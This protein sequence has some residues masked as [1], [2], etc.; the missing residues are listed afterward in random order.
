MGSLSLAIFF[1]NL[2]DKNKVF[3][4][5]NQKKP[6][7]SFGRCFFSPENRAALPFFL[8]SAL[9]CF[10]TRGGCGYVA[11]D[12]EKNSTFALKYHEV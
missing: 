7:K 1:K 11:R 8:P 6:N 2:T 3:R 12:D 9:M 5:N 10:P 4:A